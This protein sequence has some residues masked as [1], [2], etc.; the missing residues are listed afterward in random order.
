MKIKSKP[1]LRQYKVLRRRND[2]V[3]GYIYIFRD[4]PIGLCKIGLSRNPE[5]RK[6]Y[7]SRTYG[8]LTTVATVWVVNMRWAEKM[9]HKFYAGNRQHR[10]PG[11]DGYTEWFKA[12]TTETLEMR[13]SLYLVAGWVNFVYLLGALVVLSIFCS[14]FL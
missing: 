8:E 10:T 7:L 11:Q 12:T 9:L 3:P 1:I 4:L 14:F 13:F 6:Y 2:Y 5:R